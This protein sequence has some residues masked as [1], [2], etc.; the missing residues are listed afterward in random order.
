MHM[1]VIERNFKKI[2]ILNNLSGV[3]YARKFAVSRIVYVFSF[4]ACIHKDKILQQ[5]F[6]WFSI[7]PGSRWTLF[8]D[9]FKQ[10]NDTDE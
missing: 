2:Y 10:H 3:T 4:L 7:L 1:Y 9:C 5:M 8:N 6:F